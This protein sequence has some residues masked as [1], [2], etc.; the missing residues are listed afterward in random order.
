MCRLIGSSIKAGEHLIQRNTRYR[1]WKIYVSGSKKY[2]LQNQRNMCFKIRKNTYDTYWSAM[3]RM[4]GWSIN[5]GEHLI[6]RNTRY[7]IWKVYVSKSKKY[8]LQNE[9]N[10]CLKIREIHLGN[11]YWPAMCRMIGSSIRAGEQ[12]LILIKS[13][14]NFQ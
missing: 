3:C 5:G 2:L 12:L 13:W 1:I 14:G 6:Q 4:I 9:R 8:M 11:T 10:I 7:R